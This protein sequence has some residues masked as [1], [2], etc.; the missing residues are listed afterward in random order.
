MSGNGVFQVWLTPLAISGGREAAVRLH[1]LVG[2]QT[3]AGGV[4]HFIDRQVVATIRPCFPQ[5]R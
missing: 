4:A 1:R 3:A 2:P 5:D